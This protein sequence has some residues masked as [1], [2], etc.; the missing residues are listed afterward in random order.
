MVK[1]L[2]KRMLTDQPDPV[3]AAGVV[4]RLGAYMAGNDWSEERRVVLFQGESDIHV[5]SD[6]NK[7]DWAVMART[8]ALT[9]PGDRIEIRGIRKGGWIQVSG[10]RNLTLDARLAQHREA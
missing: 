5:L 2:F 6:A 9:Q 7:K 10:V 1:E 4:E 3:V 8:Y